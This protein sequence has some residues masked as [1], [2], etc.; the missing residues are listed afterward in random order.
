MRY[1]ELEMREGFYEFL[2]PS[3]LNIPDMFRLSDM[4]MEDIFNIESRI[5]TPREGI[6]K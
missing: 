2:M 1:S 3:S 6:C 5:I 4:S